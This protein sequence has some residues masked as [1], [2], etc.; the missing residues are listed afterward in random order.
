MNRR[1]AIGGMAAMTVGVSGI[2]STHAAVEFISTGFGLAIDDFTEI[3]GEGEPGQTYLQYPED[4]GT[5]FI[6]QNEDGLVNFMERYWDEGADFPLD[7]AMELAL[8]VCPEESNLHESYQAAFGAILYGVQVDRYESSSLAD[9]FG[10]TPENDD[11][12][13]STSFVIVYE[14]APM[15]AAM[16]YAV[17]RFSI[18]HRSENPT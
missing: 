7:D 16:D 14:L 13:A 9:Q 1:Q 10:I 8:S 12:L 11:F 2:R 3:W 18:I 17:R 4:D 5:W 15:S 6:G